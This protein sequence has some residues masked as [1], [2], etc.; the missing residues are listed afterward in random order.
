VLSVLTASWQP[1]ANWSVNGSFSGLDCKERRQTLQSTYMNP[2]W[3]FRVTGRVL[4]QN[5]FNEIPVTEFSPFVSVLGVYAPYV[6]WQLDA[7]KTLFHP[8]EVG[9]GFLARQLI[10][11]ADEGLY[12]HEFNQG[13]V[14]VT[15]SPFLLDDSTLTVRADGWDG[16]GRDFGTVGGSFEKRFG[17]TVRLLFGT[18]YS[19][20]RIDELTGKEHYRDRQFFGRVRWNASQRLELSL[21]YRYAYDSLD[22]YQIVDVICG[23]RF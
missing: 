13:Y 15:A 16:E 9:A 4:R 22:R 21:G 23:I 2:D 14:S 12:N 3:G 8:V 5:E 1:H 7:S 11:G 10:E 6:Q 18:D 19:I 17:K 20:Y